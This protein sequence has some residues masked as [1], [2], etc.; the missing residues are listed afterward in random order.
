MY[1]I[2]KVEW[3]NSNI[4]VLFDNRANVKFAS[5]ISLEMSSPNIKVGFAMKT[6][7][8]TN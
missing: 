8:T 6:T 7:P 4:Y 1:K 2:T 5:F 3:I